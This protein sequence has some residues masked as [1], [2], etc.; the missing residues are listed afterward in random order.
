MR[1]RPPLGSR[2]IAGVRER[3]VDT[4]IDA[5]PD[6]VA[7]AHVDQRRAECRRAVLDAALRPAKDDL[8]ERGDEVGTAV[9]VAAVIN[10]IHAD[11][12]LPRI[13]RFGEAEDEREKDRV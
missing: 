12:D 10:G 5:A 11:P 3:V 8:L 4:K 1:T 9:G 13:P 7:L 2:V 6:D